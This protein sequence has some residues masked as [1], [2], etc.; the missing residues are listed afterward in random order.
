MINLCQDQYGNYVI[1]NLLQKRQGEKCKDIYDALR[2]RILDMS[3]HK[4]AS[5]VIER[6]LHFGTV[7]QK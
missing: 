6:C 7:Q 5:N 1:Q 4:F 3:M 2:G